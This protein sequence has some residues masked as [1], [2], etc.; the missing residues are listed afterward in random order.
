V[1][2]IVNARRNPD[3]CGDD[4]SA[5]QTIVTDQLLLPLIHVPVLLL[6]GAHD[7]LFPPLAMRLQRLH[8]FGSRDVASVQIPATGHAV[9][10]GRTAPTLVA[11]MSAWLGARGF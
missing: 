6:A 7:A 9:T 5:V 3:P 1:V 11:D 2:A 4:A 10:L 8:F